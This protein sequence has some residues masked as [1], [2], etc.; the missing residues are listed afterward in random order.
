[1]QHPKL[2]ADCQRTMAM[3]YAERISAAAE[4]GNDSSTKKGLFGWQRSDRKSK[5]QEHER[6]VSLRDKANVADA[7]FSAIVEYLYH[8]LQVQE[9]QEE[10]FAQW[11]WMVGGRKGGGYF[12]RI[13]RGWGV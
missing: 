8:A 4:Q 13:V 2:Y 7:V 12:V 1:M 3:Y 9:L 11:R 5:E 10:A 6:V